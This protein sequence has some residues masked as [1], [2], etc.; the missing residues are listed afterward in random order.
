MPGAG[1]ASP[2]FM[3]AKIIIYLTGKPSLNGLRRREFQWSGAHGLYLYENRD[4]ELHEFNAKYDKALRTNSDMRVLVK[5]V[6]AAPIE[7][8]APIDPEVVA[9]QITIEEAEAAMRRLAPDRLKKAPG[10]KP[11]REVMEVA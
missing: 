7:Q 5:V 11:H 10:R 6:G 8:T 2:L 9:G 1:P 3:S 4:L